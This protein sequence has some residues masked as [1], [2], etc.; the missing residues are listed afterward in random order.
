MSVE[1]LSTLPYQKLPKKEVGFSLANVRFGSRA[2]A[3][4]RPLTTQSGQPDLERQ[5][6]DVYQGAAEST[7]TCFCL[8]GMNGVSSVPSA[9]EIQSAN[10]ASQRDQNRGEPHSAQN[11][12]NTVDEDA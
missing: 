5:P 8:W 10:S 6:D 2:A 1:P 7:W 12:R 9:T 3:H 11:S 4:H